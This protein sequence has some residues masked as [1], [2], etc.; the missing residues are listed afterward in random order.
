MGN[1]CLKHPK[2]WIFVLNGAFLAYTPKIQDFRHKW[3]TFHLKTQNEDFKLEE[4]TTIVIGWV[5][6]P[7]KCKAGPPIHHSF[8]KG[9]KVILTFLFLSAT[10]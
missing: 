9:A 8:A 2:F 1:F 7:L 10:F 6:V 4:T 5:G 3:K